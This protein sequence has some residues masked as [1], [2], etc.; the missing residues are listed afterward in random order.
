MLN[1]AIVVLWFV[2]VFSEP[3]NSKSDSVYPVMKGTVLQKRGCKT[4]MVLIIND[5]CKGNSYQQWHIDG[6]CCY[7]TYSIKTHCPDATETLWDFLFYGQANLRESADLALYHF[8]FGD[9][10]RCCTSLRAGSR[11]STGENWSTNRAESEPALISANFSFPPRKP[12][13]K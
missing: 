12:Q 9:H 4:K 10:L 8:R 6:P 5:L 3:G 7:K 1:A 2:S 11:W 13:E